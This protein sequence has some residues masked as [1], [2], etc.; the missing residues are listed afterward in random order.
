MACFHVCPCGKHG[1]VFTSDGGITIEASCKEM[2]SYLIRMGIKFKRLT[3]QDVFVVKRDVASSALPEKVDDVDPA[4]L[5]NAVLFNH[6][7]KHRDIIRK[8][9]ADEIICRLLHRTKESPP[10]PANL[11][12]HIKDQL[13]KSAFQA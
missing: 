3:D 6:W 4:M 8:P 10:M 7:P 5:W 1:R 2:A 11:V 9:N 12:A 13:K